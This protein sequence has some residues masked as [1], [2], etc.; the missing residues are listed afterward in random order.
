MD[1]SNKLQMAS[2][3]RTV[4]L[5]PWSKSASKNGPPGQKPLA[6]SDPRRILTPP[7]RPPCKHFRHQITLKE[8]LAILLI[9]ISHG[10]DFSTFQPCQQTVGF[11]F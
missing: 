8:N 3:T 9:Y 1:F 2:I 10:N 7:P 5:T 6:V 11:G 4:H